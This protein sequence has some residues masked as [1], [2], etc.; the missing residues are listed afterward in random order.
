MAATDSASDSVSGETSGGAHAA[1]DGTP[2]PRPIRDSVTRTRGYHHPDVP[3]PVPGLPTGRAEGSHTNCVKGKSRS[4]Q[5][6]D[7]GVSPA[8]ARP[9][10]ADAG[11]GRRRAAPDR[12]STTADRVRET[13]SRGQGPRGVGSRGVGP[14]RGRGRTG[15]PGGVSGAVSGRP[16]GGRR[17]HSVTPRR[18]RDRPAELGG[19]P[20]GSER[21]SPPPTIADR[22]PVTMADRL[23]NTVM[24]VPDDGTE[25]NTSP[26]APRRPHHQLRHRPHRWLRCRQHHPS[27]RRPYRHHPSQRLFRRRPYRPFRHRPHQTLRHRT[28][29]TDH[30][31]RTG[32][33]GRTGE[34]GWSAHAGWPQQLMTSPRPGTLP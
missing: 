18:C 6:A 22:Q 16:P 13:G 10:D 30:I 11:Q 5:A 25:P 14:G 33:T 23:T 21:R 12:A 32:A 26:P 1:H 7:V 4:G 34:T 2:K 29:R 19:R 24:A 31:P 20:A 28:L 9:R 27:R 8:A 15:Q 17:P 3:M